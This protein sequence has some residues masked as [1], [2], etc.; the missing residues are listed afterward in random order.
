MNNTIY[1]LKDY[2]KIDINFK[3]IIDSKGI[4]RSKLSTMVAMNYDI[5]III[6][7]YR[8]ST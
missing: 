2:G 3:K 1:T 5:D 4:S 7:K 6:I 8:V